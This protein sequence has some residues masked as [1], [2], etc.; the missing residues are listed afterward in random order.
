MNK[1]HEE[2]IDKNHKIV[3]VTWDDIPDDIKKL[4]EYGFYTKEEVLCKAVARK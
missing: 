1:V 2:V 4:V 3:E